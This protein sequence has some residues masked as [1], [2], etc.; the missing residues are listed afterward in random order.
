M[1]P[2]ERPLAPRDVGGHPRAVSECVFPSMRC[3]SWIIAGSVALQALTWSLSEQEC[4][5]P[6]WW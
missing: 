2:S 6:R 1:E 4:V 3:T 5:P